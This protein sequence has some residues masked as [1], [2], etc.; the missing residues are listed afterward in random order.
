MKFKWLLCCPFFKVSPFFGTIYNMMYYTAMAVEQARDREGWVT[1]RVLADGEGGFEFEGFNQ[2]LRAGRNGEGMQAQYVVLDYS[3]IGNTL[4]STHS[5]HASYT[6]SKTGGLKYL[7]RSIHFAGST[8]YKDSTCWFSPHFACTGGDCACSAIA[9][10]TFK[11]K[12]VLT[13]VH[14]NYLCG[15]LPRYKFVCCLLAFPDVHFVDWI[16][17]K[18]LSSL[19]VCI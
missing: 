3:G 13:L 10:N 1:G 5:L 17:S 7:G 12:P 15:S 6:D 8:P 9:K 4:Y 14:S 2:P 16:F 19:Q 18:R 11:N